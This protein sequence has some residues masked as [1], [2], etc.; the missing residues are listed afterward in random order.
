MGR[1]VAFVFVGAG[2]QERLIR[3]AAARHRN[4]LLFPPEDDARLAELLSAGD[5]HIVPL[6]IGADRVMWPHK[7]D[8][9]RAAGRP[10]LAVGWGEG[11]DG[12]QTVAADGLAAEIAKRAEAAR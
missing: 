7:V 12:V 11:V 1:D 3:E 8:A 4:V 6:K 2:C 10:V 9:I 5:L